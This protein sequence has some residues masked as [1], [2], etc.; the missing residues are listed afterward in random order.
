MIDQNNRESM[1]LCKKIFRSLFGKS[2]QKEK[3]LEDL[4]FDQLREDLIKDE[5][6][7]L[8]L[9]LC[10][11]G[12]YTIGVGRNL[13]ANGISEDEA[14]YLLDNDINRVF[15]E[16]KNNFDWFQQINTA[17]KAALM[18][19]CFNIGIS[20]LKKFKKMIKACAEGDWNTAAD[21]LLDSK[22]AQQVGQRANRLSEQL[23]SGVWI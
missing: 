9:Y 19:V 6:L 13:D 23:R 2:L 18:N 8:T 17:R 15:H 5:S 21:E 20:S 7:E 12:F 3:E 22:Y 1:N 10:P 4:L 14:M 16:L 11:E